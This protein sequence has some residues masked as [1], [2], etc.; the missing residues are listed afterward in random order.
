M[1]NP[2]GGYDQLTNFEFGK[3]TEVQRS[4]SLQWQ[5]Q[6]YVFGGSNERGQVSIVNGYRLERKATLDFDF[7]WGGCTVL[8]QTIIVLCFD[9]D[10]AKTCRQ[11]NNPLGSFTTLPNS[12]YDHRFIRIASFDGNKTIY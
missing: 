4:C 7:T 1:I 8:N 3:G 2:L 9:M 6:Y 5:N 10:E 11:S 12:T